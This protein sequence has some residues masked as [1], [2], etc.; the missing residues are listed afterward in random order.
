[1]T[2]TEKFIA[3]AIEIAKDNTHGYSQLDRWSIDYDCSSLMYICAEAAGYNINKS[4]PR[5]TGTMINDFEALGFRVDAFDGNLSDL[6]AGDILLNTQEHTALYIGNG[7][8]VEASSSE[9][10]GKSG[11][12]GDQTGYEIHVRNVYNFPWTHVLTPPKESAP[13]P[14]PAPAPTP[15]TEPKTDRAIDSAL[16]VIAAYVIKGRFGNGAERKEAIYKAVQ[17][18]VNSILKKG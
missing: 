13:T 2:K 7:Q 12:T 9:T 15:S 16:E 3:K 17:T 4:N 5:Y 10:G 11:K 18:K 8:I 14:A 1:M 6:E